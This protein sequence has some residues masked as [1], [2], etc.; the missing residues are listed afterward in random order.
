M[1]WEEGRGAMR[2]RNLERYG[3]GARRVEGPWEVERVASFCVKTEEGME[4]SM[5][6]EESEKWRGVVC[7][8]V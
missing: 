1:V 8:D 5:W 2:G 7:E 3:L 4:T 6:G